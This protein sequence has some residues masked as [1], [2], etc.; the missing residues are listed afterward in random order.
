MTANSGAF[1]AVTLDGSTSTGYAGQELR[2]AWG[3]ATGNPAKI[4]LTSTSGATTSFTP[5]IGGNYGFTLSVRNGPCP[6]SA[7]ANYQI[8]ANCNELSANLRQVP[9][10]ANAASISVPSA[11]DGTKFAVIELDGT[12]LVYRETG[13]RDPSAQSGNLRSLKY[14]WTVE[15]SPAC[16]CYMQDKGSVSVDTKESE[17]DPVVTDV[18]SANATV[19]ISSSEYCKT[20]T[21]TTTTT[22]TTLANHHYTLPHTCFKPDCPGQYRI[23]LKIEDGCTEAT[24]TATVS[25]ACAPAPQVTIE[26]PGT[27]TLEGNKFKRVDLRANVV[28]P[29]SEHLTY[30][31]TLDKIPDGSRLKAGGYLSITNAQM[32]QASIVPD[33]AGTYQFSFR[34]NDGCNEAQTAT[35]SMT[36]QCNSNLQIESA[37]STPVNIDWVG[38]ANEANGINNFDN[39]MFKLTG[40]TDRTKCNVLSTRWTRVSRGCSD[41]YPPGATKPPVPVVEAGCSRCEYTCK[42]DLLEQPCNDLKVNPKYKPPTLTGGTLADKCVAKFKP[43]HPGTYTLQ[44]SVDDCCGRSVDTAIVVAKCATGIKASVDAQTIDSSLTCTEWE[45]RTLRGVPETLR[46]AGPPNA[47]HSCP[48]QAADPCT[49]AV[50][51][52]CCP[53]TTTKCCNYKCPQCAQ[54]PQCPQCPGYT[55]AS[56]GSAEYKLPYNTAFTASTESSSNPFIMK[57]SLL[58]GIVAPLGGMIVFSLVGNIVL[59]SMYRSKQSEIPY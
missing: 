12:G 49:Q 1:P 4:A 55:A 54:C 21:T 5:T 53:K 18:P 39:K 20:T 34:V 45:P 58:T 7:V 42:W 23:Q 27:Q 13:S 16:S 29:A 9:G 48:V 44:F 24:A 26:S 22:I 32:P 14:T 6:E 56:A 47:V 36:V 3:V 17:S 8:S 59:V 19:S 46:D 43:E 28:F 38:R 50:K 51:D 37:V 31:W 25:A 52:A 41:P 11:W 30:Q 40:S 15:S 57:A 35:M 2:Y 10:S 33:R